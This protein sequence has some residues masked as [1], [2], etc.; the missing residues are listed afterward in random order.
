[1]VFIAGKQNVALATN[2]ESL[3]NTTFLQNGFYCREAKRNT[4][5]CKKIACK[6]SIPAKWFS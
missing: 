3:V 1:V 6:Y 5:N 4:C 2:S